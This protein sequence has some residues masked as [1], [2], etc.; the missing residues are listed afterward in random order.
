MAFRSLHADGDDAVRWTALI[1]RLPAE[2]RDIHFLPAYGSIY[3]DTHGYRP[4]LALYEEGD[5]FVLQPF[6]RRR[7]STLPFLTDRPDGEAFT[8]VANPY[9][10][11][12]PLSNAVNLDDANQLYRRFDDA[13]ST[14][15][16]EERIASEFTSLHPLMVRDQLAI[17]GDA[18]SSRH[19][20]DVVILDLSQQEDDLLKGLRKGHRSTVK[21]AERSGVRVEKV[22]TSDENLATFSALYEATMERRQAAPRWFM[23]KGFF[24]TTAR[25]L[26]PERTTLFFAYIDGQVESGCLLMHDYETAYYHFAGTAAK[27]PEIGASTLLVWKAALWAKAAG[28]TTLHLGG[29]VTSQPDDSLLRF[30]AGFSKLRAPLFTYFRV[31]DSGAYQALSTR[32]RA[33]ERAT[34]GAESSSDFEPI[35]RR[36]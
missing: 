23:P 25:R 3:R 2:R 21:M 31:R 20:K 5:T 18:A 36:Q 8:D 29:G 35:Y 28:Y 4:F 19:E 24:Q 27:H 6:V 14:W 1:D 17:V 16:A 22:E 33:H 30:K 7:L 15:C 10:F 12:G 13:F 11:G 34:M 26:G 9:G 32:K